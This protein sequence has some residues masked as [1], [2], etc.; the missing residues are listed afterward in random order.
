MYGINELKKA[1]TKQASIFVCKLKR[2]S[3]IK[4]NKTI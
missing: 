4:K 3:L 1:E 2:I